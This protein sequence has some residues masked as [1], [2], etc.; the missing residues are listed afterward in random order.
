MYKKA[1]RLGLIGLGAFGR[2]IVKHLSPYFEILA[3]DPDPSARAYV[4]RHNVSLC[5]LAEVASCPLIIMA[6]PV[7][8]FQA[9]AKDMVPHLRRDALVMD[10]G[11][12]KVKPAQWLQDIL[13]PHVGILCTHPLFGPQSARLGL[14]GHEIV[15]CP[16]R[17]RHLKPII[18]FLEQ[19]LD[20]KVSVTTPEDHDKALAA[21]Q[22]ITHLIAKV[23]SG[24][25]PLPTEHTTKSYD[26]M[27]QGVKYVANDSD[28]L[29]LSIERDNPYAADIRRRF[30]AEISALQN[31]LESKA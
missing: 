25:E 22:G 16:V 5:S 21:V 10:V 19:T 7:R 6:A 4:R 1:H 14:N 26:L 11:S 8:H 24:L 31:R 12:V 20:L 18:R 9:L 15:I 28:E 29:F 30:F 3:Y 27:M 17:V 13:P 23:L 2:L